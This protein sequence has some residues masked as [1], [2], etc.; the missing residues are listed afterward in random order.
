[1][2]THR[3]P[4]NDPTV[5]SLLRNRAYRTLITAQL[6]S[7]LG[8]WLHLLALLTLVGI[9]WQATPMQITWVTLCAVVPMLLGGPFAGA[10][11]DRLNRKWLMII[12]DVL[13]AGLVFGLIFADQLW[14]VYII[15][16]LKGLF[17][18]LFSPAKSGK[19]KEV[20]PQ[21]HL[22]Q[23]VSISSF[24]EQGSKIAGPA[25]GGL[26]LA[27]VG[28]HWCF[29]IDAFTFL[30]SG[31]ILLALPGHALFD[32]VDEE[33]TVRTQERQRSFLSDTAAGLR[34][35]IRIP[36]IAYGTLLLCLVLLVLQLADSQTI[37]LLRQIPNINEDLLGW[38]I[39]AS[40]VGTLLAA[41]L[42]ARIKSSHLLQMSLGAALM[43]IVFGLA[44]PFTGMLH[45]GWHTTF[46]LTSSFLL[47][48]IG[49]GFTFI[50][51]QIMLQEQTP[52]H[53]TGRVFGTVNSLT[54]AS[55]VA[56][57]LLG[58]ILVTA[59]GVIP[60]FI[61]TGASLVV[62]SLAILC[63]KKWI[64]IRQSKQAIPT[65]VHQPLK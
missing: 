62:M 20:V 13:R 46:I 43:G 23:A 65:A 53:M 36:V 49:A 38:C 50:P 47:A 22:Q 31:I 52:V 37:I 56:G 48:G 15:L 32:T 5:A 45:A 24:I 39:T 54:S 7:N 21:E 63:I 30:L 60:A 57:P 14:Q 28:I 59:S 33:D 41:L 25:L 19:I 12:S 29:V 2:E 27:A 64:D 3:S 1:M 17:D 58:G 42:C 18:V 8:D 16:V 6:I 11:A 35:L 4:G 26:L 10:L 9:K 51:F 44:G 61:L 34:Y 55:S 40:G